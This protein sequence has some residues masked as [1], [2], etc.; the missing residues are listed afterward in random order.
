L[1]VPSAAVVSRSPG[2]RRD[3]G[4]PLAQR[5]RQVGHRGDVGGE[6]L[7]QPLRDLLAAKRLLAQPGEEAGQRVRREIEQVGHRRR[8]RGRVLPGPSIILQRL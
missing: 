5:A 1:R 6:P 3:R 2:D 8:D 4:E 7:V